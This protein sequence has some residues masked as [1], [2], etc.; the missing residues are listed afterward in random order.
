WDSDD[1]LRED[2]E[3]YPGYPN[4]SPYYGT[5]EYVHGLEQ[6]KPVG[7][8]DS[9]LA[10]TSRVLNPNWR[11]VFES[12]VLPDGTKADCAILDGLAC[13][14]RR[15]VRRRHRRFRGWCCSGRTA[16]GI[17][18]GSSGSSSFRGC[19]CSCR[20]RGLRY[21]TVKSCWPSGKSSRSH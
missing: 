19:R 5:V 1:I 2:R 11:G 6:D 15:R 21:A 3:P 10:G 9:Q 17:C 13:S 4:S 8:V 12:S 18:G 14:T 16:R 7:A 20:R